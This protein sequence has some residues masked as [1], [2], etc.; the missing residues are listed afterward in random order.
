MQLQSSFLHAAGC[1]VSN[2]SDSRLAVHR[3]R[4]YPRRHLRG[5]RASRETELL[6]EPLSD[7]SFSPFDRV[8]VL[9][10]ALPYLQQFRNKTIVIKYGGAA[11]KDP[12]LKAGVI[13]DLVLLACVGV[14]PV[15]VHGGGPEINTW[16][17]K[18]GIKAEFKN[19]L[20]VTDAATMD[21]VE[22]V[23]GGRVNKGLVTLIQQ[24]GGQAVGLCGKD[25]N[26]IRARQMVEK[27]IGFVGDITSVN[28][29]L[30]VALVNEEYIPVVASVAADPVTG[31]ALNVNADI[32]AG[33][34]MKA[35]AMLLDV[36]T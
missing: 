25:S 23:L 7:K 32:A 3:P 19:G 27:D 14:R 20:R 36:A 28:K 34:V 16:L 2:I 21:V 6:K 8:S 4:V 5:I 22:M 29:D 26:I 24:A 30:I 18:L 12:M 11:M 31:Q 1:R 17:D 10:E 13:K 15:L 33:E 35:P 9:S